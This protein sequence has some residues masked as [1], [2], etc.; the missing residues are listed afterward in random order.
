VTWSLPAYLAGLA[1][2]PA[3]VLIVTGV[4]LAVETGKEIECRVCGYSTG[5]MHDTARLTCWSRWRWHKL[6]T[7]HHTRWGEPL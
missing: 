3:A 7:R 4:V 2:I 5:P 1:T 6:A